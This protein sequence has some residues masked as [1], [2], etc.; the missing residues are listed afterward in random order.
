MAQFQVKKSNIARIRQRYSFDD[1]QAD[2][3]RS[4]Q[5]QRWLLLP[6]R[7]LIRRTLLHFSGPWRSRRRAAGSGR[8]R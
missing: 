3:Q 6:L 8:R 4:M 7:P 5:L 1:F 2:F